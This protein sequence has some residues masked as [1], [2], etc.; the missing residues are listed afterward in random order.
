[1]N[2]Q[3][4]DL[5]L[6]ALFTN[7]TQGRQEAPVSF[8]IAVLSPA[9]THTN[10]VK[11]SS[12]LEI[13]VH[14]REPSSTFI[15][16]SLLISP[17]P[18]AI[19]NSRKPNRAPAL[20][21]AIPSHT[22]ALTVFSLKLLCVIAAIR[23]DGEKDNI[24]EILQLA[25][26]DEPGSTSNTI[27]SLDPLASNTWEN[28]PPVRTIIAPIRCK[29]LWRQFRKQTKY[30]VDRAIAAQEI[31]KKKNNQLSPPWAITATL[32][33]GFNEFWTILSVNDS[34]C[35]E[36]SECDEKPI[37]TILLDGCYMDSEDEFDNSL[38]ALSL[39]PTQAISTEPNEPP[40]EDDSI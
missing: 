19:Q 1:M 17:L 22:L 16:T 18:L 30:T 5:I 10:E 32:I 39:E 20:S 36:E 34:L 8:R 4:A 38:Q 21:A 11:S 25:F 15:R 24:E 3:A 2:L 28:V 31:Y 37:F 26:M 27:G 23:V 9:I 40:V 14:T 12:A 35:D 29:L 13:F 7:R 6:P 33:L